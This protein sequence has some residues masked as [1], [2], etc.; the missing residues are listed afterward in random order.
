M[1]ALSM[2]QPWAS[3]VIDGRKK[4]ETRSWRAPAW[5]IGVDLAIHATKG[6]CD[7]DLAE[8]CGYDLRVFP[9]GA[10]LGVVRVDRCQQFTQEFYDDITLLSSDPHYPEG[11]Y[12]DFYPGRWGWFV[13]VIEK[14]PTP[15]PQR[16][17]QGIFE[18]CKPVEQRR[19]SQ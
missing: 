11:K 9:L 7:K 4:I 12:G 14:F 6:N 19:G 2:W 1:K 5:L 8:E 16:G 10:I 3:L 18:W 17:A 15:Y 13:T